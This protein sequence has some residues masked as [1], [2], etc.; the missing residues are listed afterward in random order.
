MCLAQLFGVSEICVVV[1]S[2][3]VCVVSSKHCLLWLFPCFAVFFHVCTCTEFHRQYMYRQYMHAYMLYVMYMYH[4]CYVDHVV[5][6]VSFSVFFCLFV[7]RVF[8]CSLFLPHSPPVDPSEGEEWQPLPDG[9]SYGTDL[10]RYLKETFG[11]YF[12]IC[13]AGIAQNNDGWPISN[14]PGQLSDI[15][16]LA[17]HSVQA[18]PI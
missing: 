13:V 15:H 10:V 14:Q 12:S 3:P 6:F 17:V 16:V 7:L 1:G 2:G 18:T 9:F 4:V 11:D 5:V 8:L